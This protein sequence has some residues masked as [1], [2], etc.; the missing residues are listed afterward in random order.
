VYECENICKISKIVEIGF[1]QVWKLSRY[2]Q[3]NKCL[4]GTGE[5]ISLVLPATGH[6]FPY[7]QWNQ[8]AVRCQEGSVGEG[9]ASVIQ[10][11]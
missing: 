3:P 10:K 1:Q 11:Q 8:A 4:L 5:S 2:Q 9:T 6:R 7:L